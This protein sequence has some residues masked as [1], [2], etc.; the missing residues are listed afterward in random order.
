MK[1]AANVFGGITTYLLCL[2][3]YL[4]YRLE[5]RFKL[6]ILLLVWGRLLNNLIVFY[7]NNNYIYVLHSIL[8][9]GVR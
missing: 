7:I 1:I 5:I 9:Y 2:Y 3:N 4:F 6:A 8:K